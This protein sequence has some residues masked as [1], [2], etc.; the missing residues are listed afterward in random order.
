[1]RKNVDQEPI[2]KQSEGGLLVLTKGAKHDFGPCARTPI[3]KPINSVDMNKLKTTLLT[4]V[5]ALALL[6][7][8]LQTQ[9]QAYRQGE[10]AVAGGLG[11]GGY[12]IASFYSG[13]GSL[14]IV[15]HGEYGFSDIV[16]GG[17]FVGFRFWNS[18]LLDLSPSLAFGGRAS[19]HLFPILN[20]YADTDIDDSQADVYLT[21]LA[22]I[23]LRDNDFPGDDRFIFGTAIGGKYYF[24]DALGAFLELGAGA[25]TYGTIGVIFRLGGY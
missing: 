4:L 13:I 18:E 2:R 20:Q 22:G 1:M 11:F 25:L 24:S 9:A 6:F 10:L 15:F 21:L 5:C 19:G 16:S 17:G 14:P 12:G 8:S 7:T 3:I 23:E